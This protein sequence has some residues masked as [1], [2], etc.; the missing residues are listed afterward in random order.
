[1]AMMRLATMVSTMMMFGALFL[2]CE[3]TDEAAP[4]A[5]GE[6]VWT[7]AGTQEDGTDT[8]PETGTPAGENTGNTGTETPVNP[9]TGAPAG[10]CDQLVNKLKTCGAITEGVAACTEPSTTLSTCA[11]DCWL[12]SDC[13]SVTQAICGDQIAMDTLDACTD[14][15]GK[16]PCANGEKHISLDWFCDGISDCSDGSD[17]VACQ[18]FF[19]CA[20]GLKSVKP[21]WQCDGI[22]DC[23]DK[24]DEQACAGFVSCADGLMGVP[25]SKVCDGWDNCAD[26][27]DEAGCPMFACADGTKEIM[28]NDQCDGFAQCDDESDE[29]GCPSF[30]CADGSKEI[31]LVWQCDILVDC[32][33]GSDEVGCE[34]E[35]S[36][37]TGTGTSE[38]SSGSGEPPYTCPDGSTIAGGWVCDDYSDCPSGADEQGCPAKAEALCASGTPTNNPPGMYITGSSFS[39][40]DGWED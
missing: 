32:P 35:T 4:A 12:A 9:T 39:D 14:S 11:M 6:Q 7:P 28:L 17:E 26:A 37:G 40:D 29:L 33:D 21:E 10:T 38:P 8:T 5:G 3:A 19:Q 22:A 31:P 36:T 24:S 18:G 25:E 30:M 27:S 13:V 20:D 34:E 23:D 2:G 1:V 15:C 16:A